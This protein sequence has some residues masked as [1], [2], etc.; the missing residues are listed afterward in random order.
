MQVFQRESDYLLERRAAILRRLFFISTMRMYDN[1]FTR[2]LHR[3]LA[4]R[5]AKRAILKSA[6]LNC[7]LIDRSKSVVLLLCALLA[8]M[9]IV[10]PVCPA[11]DGLG[12]LGGSGNGNRNINHTHLA[13]TALPPTGDDCNGVCSCCGFHWL[14]P[15]EQQLPTVAIVTT[16]S[17]PHDEPYPSRLAPP[18]FLPPRS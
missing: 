4:N 7:Y 14:L 1:P 13:G 12:N 3:V 6:M 2:S 9:S 10:S 8:V 18:P 11:C 15:I 5:R 17:I 16:L